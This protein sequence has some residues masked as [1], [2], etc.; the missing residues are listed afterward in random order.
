MI[1]ATEN[2]DREMILLLLSMGASV[3]YA[4]EQAQSSL[5]D[6]AI[7]SGNAHIVELL[8]RRGYFKS[9]QSTEATGSPDESN[10]VIMAYI[11]D[12]QGIEEL[13]G[14]YGSPLPA[15]IFE[16]ALRAASARGHLPVVRL[17]MH[18]GVQINSRDAVDRTALHYA[19]KHLHWDV[20]DSGAAAVHLFERGRGRGGQVSASR[21]CRPH[22]HYLVCQAVRETRV[23]VPG[24]ARCR[25]EDAEGDLGKQ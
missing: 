13:L 5:Y 19:T 12:A 1:L 8:V 6:I 20:A 7:R 23:A 9:Q 21:V 2:T 14:K 4:W 25:E 10:L 24:A 18:K 22:R 15:Q 3:K 16:E 17:L 11:G